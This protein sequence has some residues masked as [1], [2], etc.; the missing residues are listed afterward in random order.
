MAPQV[1]VDGLT[2]DLRKLGL[3][4]DAEQGILDAFAPVLGETHMVP[5]AASAT[6]RP[7]YSTAQI[8][9]LPFGT[10]TSPPLIHRGAREP[11]HEP[12]LPASRLVPLDVHGVLDL[13]DRVSRECI[14]GELAAR[15]FSYV[16]VGGGTAGLVLANRLSEDPENKVLVIEA[17]PLQ[18]E[19][20]DIETPNM[21][22]NLF[23]TEI[24]WNYRS[25]PQKGLYER[26]VVYPRGK[27][28]G[29]TSNF[30]ACVW[31]RGPAVDYDAWERLGNPG[32][33]WADL[34][35][36]QR[37]SETF[38]VPVPA[39]NL[40][41]ATA[42]DP[43]WV[44]SAHG[45]GGPV[46]G[47]FESFRQ[48]GLREID[49]CGGAAAGV[50]YVAESIRADTETRSSSEASYLSPVLG[51]ENLLV[52]TNAQATRIIWSSKRAPGQ[53]VKARG[54]E[55]CDA[56]NP[57]KKLVARVADEVILCGGTFNSPQLLEIS[58]I[59]NAELLP[60]C[61]IEPVVDLP[62]VGENF[63]YESLDMFE[64]DARLKEKIHQEFLHHEGPLAQ[65]APVVAFLPPGHYLDKPEYMHGLMLAHRVEDS[66][67]EHLPI[68]WA[69][70]SKKQLHVEQSLY[71]ARGM[72]EVVAMT[73]FLGGVKK[74]EGRGYI[75]VIVA[76][77]HAL[78]RGNVHITSPDPLAKP[79]IDPQMLSHPAD[80]F[81]LAHAAR[82]V[83]DMCIDPTSA[84]AEFLDLPK[85]GPG[86]LVP[87]HMDGA[88]HAMGEDAEEQAWEDWVRSNARTEH[89]PAST[90]SMLPR[91]DGGVV[92]PHLLVYGTSNVRVADLSIVPLHVATHT[93]AYM[94]G[95]KASEIIVN[96]QL[97]R[98]GC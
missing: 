22:G 44:P 55:L 53:P 23:G 70:P 83:H 33:N 45:H 84:L 26:K 5:H 65:T 19:N 78:S 95:E 16:I 52:I 36:Y 74:E 13:R 42:H 97:R 63:Q 57:S 94:V 89:H 25:I 27:V 46:E 9:P 37:R 8:P 31:S 6:R 88:A 58:G 50:G 30:N 72:I 75:G 15:K 11:F 59:G 81:Q 80:A 43:L 1:Y 82:H 66:E 91:P 18:S 73:R 60:K 29:G 51:R 96:A 87:L 12:K 35:P 40:P 92:D 24:D 56:T 64:S 47:F 90:C 48:E 49:P 38:H 21:A 54:V 93:V 79:R 2:S 62:G 34:L 14:E 85:A 69:R 41:A 76:L 28:V 71:G 3:G 61:G 10:Y 77:Q 67:H 98:R 39:A 20:P 4:K 7:I 86:H 32:W 17:G 68:A